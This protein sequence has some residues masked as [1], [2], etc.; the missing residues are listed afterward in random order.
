MQLQISAL[1]LQTAVFKLTGRT[2]LEGSASHY[3]TRLLAHR[4]HRLPAWAD[5]A[6]AHKVATWATIAVE[7]S[8]GTLIWLEPLRYP[9]LAGLVGLH[10]TIHLLMRMHLFQ[11][12]MLAALLLLAPGEDLAAL[13]SLL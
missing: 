1:Y 9:I 2:W 8:G 13:V 11:W 5:T 10:V 6:A 12:T 3:A 4:R 7:L